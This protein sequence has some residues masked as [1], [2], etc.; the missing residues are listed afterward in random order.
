MN[1]TDI[2]NT[3]TET[4]YSLYATHDNI[5]WFPLGARKTEYESIPK[6]LAAL[7][8]ANPRCD[9]HSLKEF[10]ALKFVKLTKVVT[11]EEVNYEI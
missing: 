6:L 1:E 9:R 11:I 5:K 2:L 10:R 3:K 4:F 8:N 7:G